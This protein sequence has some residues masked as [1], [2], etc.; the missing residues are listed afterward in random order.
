[1]TK[2]FSVKEYEPGEIII[3]QGSPGENLM[4][5]MDGE[6]EIIKV[7]DKSP[8]LIATLGRGAILGEMSL[9]TGKPRNA[10]AKAASKTKV[11]EFSKR[12]FNYSLINDELPILHDIVT[13]LAKRLEVTETEN[14]LYQKQIAALEKQLLRQ[15]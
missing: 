10:S 5:I 15:I 3:V 9:L 1:M 8:E 4:Y 12:T 11:I 6:V 13:Q 7:I 2:R 14:L